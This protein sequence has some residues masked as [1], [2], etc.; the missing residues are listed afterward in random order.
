MT[1]RSF[2]RDPARFGLVAM[3]IALTGCSAGPSLW[4]QWEEFCDAKGGYIS[5]I[6]PGG[7]N[8]P[9]YRC[10]VH[11]REVPLPTYTEQS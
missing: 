10:I 8:G 4:D 1:A 2:L 7:W 3:L 6:D 11:G 9:V 5:M